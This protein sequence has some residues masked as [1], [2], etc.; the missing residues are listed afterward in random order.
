MA[1]ENGR[2][3][4]KPDFKEQYA[5]FKGDMEKRFREAHKENQAFYQAPQK[6]IM[7][8]VA[9]LPS[10]KDNKRHPFRGE[11]AAILMQAAR[12]KGFS[13]LR[14]VAVGQMTNRL[15]KYG[16]P[17][18]LYAAKGEEPTVVVH[19]N[20]KTHEP[21]YFV[22]YFNVEQLASVSK[23]KIP[24]LA[25]SNFRD[26]A[27]QKMAEYL[28]EN[29]SF[30]KGDEL[31]MQFFNASKYGYE[32]AQKMDRS[33]G[34]KRVEAIQAVK[35]DEIADTPEMKLMQEAK[36]IYGMDPELKAEKYMEMAA[37]EVLKDG[38]FTQEEVAK[39][40]NRV[41]P[42]PTGLDF[43]NEWNRSYGLRTVKAAMNSLEQQKQ[44]A[45]ATTR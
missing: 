9:G 31:S 5:E 22:R 8:P 7:A 11:N 16:K 15:D 26:T 45:K 4:A 40:L 38:K 19:R 35:L 21:E 20:L 24:P 14:W 28:K 17:D 30:K 43:N 1:M 10:A 34:E 2:T 41:S 27:T 23:S 18:P 37:V 44:H 36:K 13:D 42:V 32:E 29:I 6:F 12:D 25:P 3:A 33:F 39:A